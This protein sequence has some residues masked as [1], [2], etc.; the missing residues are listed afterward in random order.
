MS[1]ESLGELKRLVSRIN[2]PSLQEEFVKWIDINV[3]VFVSSRV[4]EVPMSG[5]ETP[6]S[7]AL[8]HLLMMDLVNYIYDTVKGEST[9]YTLNPHRRL[10]RYSLG[11]FGPLKK[12]VIK[13][14]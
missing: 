2:N 8:K 12:E 5:N 11:V 6:T 13:N 10:H 1:T 14:E 4:L 7:E 3:R 9:F